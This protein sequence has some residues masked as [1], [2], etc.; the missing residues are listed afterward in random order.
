MTAHWIDLLNRLNLWLTVA[1]NATVEPRNSRYRAAQNNPR[2]TSIHFISKYFLLSLK[3]HEPRPPRQIFE[4]NFHGYWKCI[5]HCRLQNMNWSRKICSHFIVLNP[6]PDW[7][8]WKFV[9]KFCLGG[10]GSCSR[11]VKVCT[12]SVGMNGHIDYIGI[13]F[14]KNS[15][16]LRI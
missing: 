15:D 3:I 7:L 12:Y 14:L 2:K 6:T 11:T 9:S 16:P 13:L 8:I 10:H 4:A 5:T 1:L